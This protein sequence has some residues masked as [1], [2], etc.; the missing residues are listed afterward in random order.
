MAEC[1]RSGEFSTSLWQFLR[2]HQGEIIDAWLERV[3]GLSP[4]R[5]LPD[6]VLLDHLPAIL[7]SIADVVESA[8]AD[9]EI[10]LGEA[11]GNHARDRL[12][13][14]FDLDEVVTEYGL[15]RRCILEFWERE[16]APTIDLAEVRRLDDAIDRS[17]T[18]A[19]R[20]YA[21]ARERMLRALDR[22][23]EAALGSQDLDRFLDEL[24]QATVQ[25]T[26]AVDCAVV[27]L[28]EGDRLCLRAAVGLGNDTREEHLL[29]VGE[30]FSGRIAAERRPRFVRDASSDPEVTIPAM[31]TSGIRA[32]YGVP[33]THGDAVIG[34][35]HMGSRTAFA[36]SQEDKL[37]FRSMASRATAILVEAQLVAER[38][39]AAREQKQLLVRLEAERRWLRAILEQL[40][41]GVVIA[42]APSGKI[43]FSNQRM[44]E[45]LGRPIAPVADIAQYE[46]TPVLDSTGRVLR[47]EQLPLARAVRGEKST[48]EELLLPRATGPA[49]AIRTN[50]APVRGA[51]GTVLGAILTVDDI[52]ERR[53]AEEEQRFLKEATA[54]LASSLD[55]RETL[56]C[57]AKLAVPALADWCAV[58]I[59]TSGGTS[60]QL[61][62][63]HVD[64]AKVELAHELRRRYPLDPDAPHGVPHVLRTGEPEL[65]EHIPDE[66]LARSARDPAHLELLHSLGLRSAMVVPMSAR[67][68][69][70]GVISFI[71]AE[72]GRHY[73]T[74]DLETAQGL[75]ARA[76][77]AIDN[78]RLYREARQAA[79]AREEILAIVSHDLKNPLGAID[80]DIQLLLRHPLASD[81]ATR[82]QLE[83][84]QRSS[85]RMSHLV[86]NLLDMGSIQ[87]NRL[88]MNAAVHPAEPLVI[89]SI[90]LNEPLAMNKGIELRRELRLAGIELCCDR[91][92]VQQVFGNLLGNAIK[93]CGRGDRITV[94][95]RPEGDHVHL[96]V[97]DS[98]PGIAEEELARVFEPYWSAERHAR[99]GTGLGLY[100]TKGIVE[101][102][103][104]RLWVESEPRAGSTF[105]FT[106]PIA[107]AR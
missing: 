39:R 94:R 86:G 67:G 61:A 64:P 48:G 31:R 22:I 58:E 36:F 50:A 46:R 49:I 56:A 105:H 71:A 53:K 34:V 82:K 12:A 88:A 83:R 55:F 96:A 40:P 79:R 47:G 32:L 106:L 25:S 5:E 62:V 72:S 10:H 107:G 1:A 30:G 13:R 60:E 9:P 97:S 87:A 38:D 8:P 4:A 41:S 14:G 81:P 18:D 2:S 101:A 78:A 59:A 63:E 51:G 42:E 43:V 57:M 6:L 23:S 80:L 44:E 65:Y 92:R 54:A 3:R 24:L 21:R 69:T 35:A 27:M 73:T 29:T 28:R 7:A 16:I 15:L 75:A 99:Q 93:F 90:E 19:A 26:E 76:A 91:E 45:I 33:L 103:G 70:I 89:E 98:G 68:R 11:P 37:L 17:V 102:H 74:R 85:G 104:G 77:L 52:T 66:L 84:L 100:I 20:R 95:G